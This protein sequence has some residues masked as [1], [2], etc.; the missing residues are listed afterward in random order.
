MEKQA[1]KKTTFVV[2]GRAKMFYFFEK[3]R[4]SPVLREKKW[5]EKPDLNRRPPGPQPGALT[6]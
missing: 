5:G 2:K 3:N 4:K 1:F 6:N